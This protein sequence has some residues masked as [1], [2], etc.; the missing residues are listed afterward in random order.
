MDSSDR[1]F[2]DYSA[3]KLRQMTGRIE[4]CLGRLNFTWFYLLCGVAANL[5]Q[6][7]VDPASTVPT[8]GAS[9][10]ISGVLGAYFLLY[11]R[12]RISTLIPLFLFFPIIQIRAWLFLIFWFLIQLQSGTLA[13]FTAGS[14]IAWW[15]HVGGFIAGMALVKLIKR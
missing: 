7:I 8:I 9:G 10:A 3:R 1:L 2:L 14:G 13:L 5:S 6:T 12:A 4:D 11:P 15:A